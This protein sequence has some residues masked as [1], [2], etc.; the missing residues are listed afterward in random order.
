MLDAK[1]EGRFQ[2]CVERCQGSAAALLEL[3]RTDFPCFRDVAEYRGQAQVSLLKRAQILVADVWALFEGQGL[4]RFH[5]VDSA[6][7]MFADYRVP[8][9]L[10][11]F[12]ALKYSPQLDEELRKPRSR[13]LNGCQFEVEIRGCSIE[14]V[15]RI[16][17]ATNERLQQ[18][19]QQ[20]DDQLSVNCI[21][22]DYFLWAFRREKADE[23]KRMAIPFHKVRSIYY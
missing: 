4:G 10:L 13:L 7:T 9:S 2:R 1:Y 18:Q 3:V 8:Q 15:A 12:G 16:V 20:Q 23:I 19:D 5:D 22:A 11:Y 14:A 17:R 21:L 6:I